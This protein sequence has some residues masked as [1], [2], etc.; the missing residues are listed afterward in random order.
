MATRTWIKAEDFCTS[1][2]DGTHDSPKPVAGGKH[3]ITSRHIIGGRI[4]LMK[5]YQ[6][7]QADFAKIQAR[8]KVDRWDVLI[9]MIGTVGEVCLVSEEP[10]FAIKNIGL[11]KV[12]NELRGRWLYNYLRTEEG[13]RSIR[14]RLAGTTQAYISL[15]ALRALPVP[16]T[17]EGEMRAVNSIIARLED[18]I[19]LN[20]Q[21][22]Q[23]LEAMAQAIFR[24]WFV[25]F[26]PVRRKLAGECDPVAIMGGLTPDLARAAKLA[27]LFPDALAD[28][29]PT[30]WS[31]VPLLT[32]ARLVSGGTPK[33]DTSE[34]WGGSIAWAS[35]KDVSQCGQ[36]FLLETERTIT[37]LGLAKSATR[38]VPALATVVVA[39]GATTGRYCMF[40]AEMAMNQTCYALVSKA[41]TPFW[42]N[43][44][45]GAEVER[46]VQAAHGSVFDTITTRTIETAEVISGSADVVGAFESVVAPLFQRILLALQENA[47]LAE[48]RDYLLPRLMSGKVR[49]ADDQTE[50]AA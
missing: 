24:D 41:E 30:G 11:F 10:D 43:L 50:A 23:T 40:G 27:A 5:A 45:F 3:L 16:V 38:L 20:R 2:R 47:T 37:D 14:E 33:T 48:T 42:L 49:V 15:A 12:A 21:M 19:E 31:Q 35:A 1:V 22:N 7:S 4:D 36:T 34:Y 18:K 29:I 6:I 32:L 17:S 8:S 13:Q 44:A 46:L 26:G 9:T 39:R 28:R 25:D